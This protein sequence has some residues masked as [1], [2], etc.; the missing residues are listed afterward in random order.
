MSTSPRR[1]NQRAY[2]R[3][4]IEPMYSSVTVQ[5]VLDMTMRKL[6]GHAYD[7]SEVGTRLE[8][9]EALEV[10]EHVSLCLRLPGETE[11]IF[12]AGEVIWV[13]DELDDPGPRRM[14][15]QFAHFLS[16]DDRK[17]LLRYLGSQALQRA[18]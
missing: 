18:A 13:H 5:R 10:G 14:A 17:H 8:L 16:E 1:V 3:F 9:D 12:V 7:I 6:E 4:R 15:I 11:S 2:E